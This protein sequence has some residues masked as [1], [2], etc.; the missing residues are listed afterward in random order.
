MRAQFPD[1][2]FRH[3]MSVDSDKS[4]DGDSRCRTE[5]WRIMRI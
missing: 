1:G 2:I 4:V 3:D 5:L